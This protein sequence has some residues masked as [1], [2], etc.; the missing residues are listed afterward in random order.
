[1]GL[2]LSRLQYCR[3]QELGSAV[4]SAPRQP[5]LAKHPAND[6]ERT[7]EH[8]MKQ[9]QSLVFLAYFLLYFLK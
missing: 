4:C 9:V 2:D 7:D 8:Q 1:M 5:A 6:A 3:E